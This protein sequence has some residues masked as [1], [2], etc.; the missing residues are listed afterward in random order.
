MVFQVFD[1]LRLLVCLMRKKHI[2]V[3]A[4]EPDFAADVEIGEAVH[5]VGQDELRSG[6]RVLGRLGR[7]LINDARHLLSRSL[8]IV[9]FN[10]CHT[11]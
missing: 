8:Y 6:V 5:L 7:L 2:A 10:I 9:F 11:I 3:G 4:V 1:S